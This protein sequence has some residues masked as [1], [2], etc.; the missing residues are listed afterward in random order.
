MIRKLSGKR[1]WRL[2][3]KK[4]GKNLGTFKTKKAAKK[5]ER[6]INWFKSHKK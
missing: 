6:Q 4:T 2:F 3:S 5:R 1:K